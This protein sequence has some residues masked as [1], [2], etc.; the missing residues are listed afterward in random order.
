MKKIM[1]TMMTMICV[2][3]INKV[4]KRIATVYSKCK[5][6]DKS[7]A[8]QTNSHHMGKVDN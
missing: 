4:T 7:M 1:N 3:K 8:I 2:M 5:L 6:V